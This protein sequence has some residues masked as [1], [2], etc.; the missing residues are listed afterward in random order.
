MQPEADS[1]ADLL[2][3]GTDRLA[4]FIAT[5]KHVFGMFYIPYFVYVHMFLYIYIS[6]GTT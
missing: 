6:C 3:P 1:P 5:G 2:A 4:A